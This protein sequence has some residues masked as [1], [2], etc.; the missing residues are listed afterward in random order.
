MSAR[1]LRTLVILMAVWCVVIGG[2]GAV[3][4]VVSVRE[5]NER[6]AECRDAMEWLGRSPAVC[7]R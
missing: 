6:V 1:A 3:V 2:I 5:T 4:L 7:T